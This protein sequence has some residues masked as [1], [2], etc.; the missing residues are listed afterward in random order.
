MDGNMLAGWV[1]G[2]IIVVIAILINVSYLRS[3]Q[4]QSRL[5]K[6][7]AQIDQPLANASVGSSI[8]CRGSLHQAA[9]APEVCFYLA[10][11]TEGLIWP[12]EP[13]VTPKAGGRWT[14][15]VHTEGC[16]DT[17]SISLWAVLPSG[18]R[19]IHIWLDN[20]RRTDDYPGLTVLPGARRLAEVCELRLEPGA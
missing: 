6:L 3:R 10:V 17:F 18:A 14:A 11:E 19:H 4:V 8:A 16:P 15:T 13:P 2:A 12:K 1:I 7:S 9:E 20:G 5:A